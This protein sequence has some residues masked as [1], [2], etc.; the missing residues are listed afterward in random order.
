MSVK[1][2]SPQLVTIYDASRAYNGYTLY[3]T[4]GTKDIWLVNMR[5]QFVHRW[6]RPDFPGFHAKLLPNGNL[7]VGVAVPNG[8][9]MHL[10]G[11][12]GILAELDWDSNVVWKYEDLY[13]NSHDWYRMKNGNTLISHRIP[14]PNDTA[15]KVK[16]GFPGSEWNGIIWNDCL[17]EINPDGKIEWEWIAHE[18][19]DFERDILCP[20]CTRVTWSYINSSVI[21]PNGNILVSLRQ[22]HTIAIIDK[23]TGE[24][25]W[26]WGP[27]ELGHQHD[28]TML[29]NGNILV[30][31]N[32]THRQNFGSEVPYSR[33]LEINPK[34]DEIEW[35]YEDERKLLFYSPV[36]SGCQRLSN[37]NTLIC[38]GA[39]GRV[40]EVTPEKEIVWEFFN[41]FYSYYRAGS[42]GLTNMTYRAYRY[43]PDY[44]GLRG[45]DLDPERFEWA[46]QEKGMPGVSQIYTPP[47]ED[48]IVSDRLSRLGY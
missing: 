2:I 26:R 44:E 38:E 15:A 25:T 37:G 47:A 17:Q 11:L 33:V 43:G 18:H 4:S 7:L 1:G 36:C 29:D 14:I 13:I 34:T 5:G 31:D 42:L 3:G 46:L 21:I 24:F 40:F 41:P 9:M 22:I 48:Q 35:E 45:R 16:G 8:P 32:G 10:S 6:Q 19:M 23:S 20:L 27:G 28:A 30:F 12:G 39:K